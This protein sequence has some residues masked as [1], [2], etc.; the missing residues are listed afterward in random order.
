MVLPIAIES[1]RSFYGTIPVALSLFVT[2]SWSF[3]KRK[4]DSLDESMDKATDRLFEIKE[5][6]DQGKEKIGGVP[7][8]SLAQIFHET[9]NSIIPGKSL[10][11]KWGIR[12]LILSAITLFLSLVFLILVGMEPLVDYL[13][14]FITL[15]LLVETLLC[16]A[17][18][19]FV[20]FF[21]ETSK[22]GEHKTINNL[23]LLPLYFSVPIFC[24]VVGVARVPILEFDHFYLD[25]IRW[26]VPDGA[27]M[28][29]QPYPIHFS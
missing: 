26:T 7:L 5:M 1:L 28:Q 15:V 12:S 25:K 23:I 14:I 21:R 16:Y 29:I 4:Y 17:Q 8:K 13:G 24:I 18:L 9:K 11:K 3:I 10:L 22:D 27:H 6:Q 2:L 19:F 20:S